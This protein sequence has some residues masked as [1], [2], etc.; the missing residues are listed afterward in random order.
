MLIWLSGSPCLWYPHIPGVCC[1]SYSIQG[2]RPQ[3]TQGTRRE[4][5]WACNRYV[6]VLPRPNRTSRDMPWTPKAT[7]AEGG[8]LNSSLV[9]VSTHCG[10]SVSLIRTQVEKV[11]NLLPI[12]C[13][14]S[15]WIRV[16]II[17]QSCSKPMIRACPPAH[18][19]KCCIVYN[20]LHHNA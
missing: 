14:Y 13:R 9:P 8:V 6:P 11:R 18:G 5:G 20:L 12:C 2:I 1:L 16:C 15:S 10:R 17:V 3:G 4:P 19:V 7:A